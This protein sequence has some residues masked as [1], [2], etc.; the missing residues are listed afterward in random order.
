M[1]NFISKILNHSDKPD[2]KDKIAIESKNNSLTYKDFSSSIFL[3][4]QFLLY[5]GLKK[6][7]IVGRMVCKKRNIK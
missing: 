4:Y 1:Q 2:F 3:S 6:Q 7:D 5:K